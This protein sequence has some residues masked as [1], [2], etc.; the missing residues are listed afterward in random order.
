MM[1]ARG[2]INA[3]L[4]T[5][6]SAIR[7]VFAAGSGGYR[8]VFDK[9]VVEKWPPQLTPA[10]KQPG[11]PSGGGADTMGEAHPPMREK[12]QPTNASRD[13]ARGGR[14][15]RAV[16]AKPP[17]LSLQLFQCRRRSLEHLLVQRV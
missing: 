6:P 1:A 3:A 13:Q 11:R 10:A 9:A 15:V 17:C 8:R 16:G 4:P 12:A 2:R 7:Q 14:P 5:L